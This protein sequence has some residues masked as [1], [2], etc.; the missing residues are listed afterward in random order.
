MTLQQ[1]MGFVSVAE[2]KNYSQSAKKLYLTQ[3]ALSNQ[4]KSLEKELGYE[5]FKR[6]SKGIELT[7]AGE[8]FIVEARYMI[9][10]FEKAKK[11]LYLTQ[12]LGTQKLRMGYTDYDIWAPL[13]PALAQLKK[14]HPEVQ[15][16]V[17]KD[18]RTTLIN[19]L[20]DGELDILITYFLREKEHPLLEFE[21]LYFF[22]SLYSTEDNHY[23][24]LAVPKNHPLAKRDFVD[25][26]DLHEEDVLWID[27]GLG[28]DIFEFQ[29]KTGL[30]LEN[31]TIKDCPSLR[32]ALSLCET[33]FGFTVIPDFAVPK[34]S[35]L[36]FIPLLKMPDSQFGVAHRKDCSHLV[37]ELI[38]LCKNL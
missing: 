19:A 17:R 1:L 21:S 7:P 36:K 9:A 23:M 27:E 8:T 35:D 28:V 3:P 6:T 38:N 31:I 37:K 34:D 16:D 24:M 2:T 4:I 15:L 10:H 25:L 12:K 26:Y 32:D 5:L 14:Q 20:E 22:E 29:E 13:K 33:G 18:E 11:N 30:D